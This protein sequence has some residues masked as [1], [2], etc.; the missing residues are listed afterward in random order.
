MSVRTPGD[1][2]K[3]YVSVVSTEEF[4]SMQKNGF[5]E[6]EDIDFTPQNGYHDAE[7]NIERVNSKGK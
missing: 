7:V 3:G 2:D 4:N 5:N 1:Q 6:E